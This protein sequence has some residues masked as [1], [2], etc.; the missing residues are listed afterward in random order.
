MGA[1]S[2]PFPTTDA[3]L[4]CVAARA[5]AAWDAWRAAEKR[6][7]VA[8]DAAERA[9]GRAREA[10]VLAERARI[11]GHLRQ[12]IT[13]RRMEA[14]KEEQWRAIEVAGAAEDAFLE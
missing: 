2:P 1:R 13:A 6:H 10:F 8:E 9:G 12:A 3:K 5:L 14:A 4:R 11:D 7:I